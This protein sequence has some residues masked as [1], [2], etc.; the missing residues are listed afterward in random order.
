MPTNIWS[1]E[2]I[3]LKLSLLVHNW[4]NTEEKIKNV[5]INNCDYLVDLNKDV[6][7]DN[8]K[9][10]VLEGKKIIFINSELCHENIRNRVLNEFRIKLYDSKNYKKEC[11]DMM[12]PH[13]RYNRIYDETNGAV[14]DLHT[15]KI[16]HVQLSKDLLIQIKPII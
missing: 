3:D 13:K 8:L 6:D 4:V 15:S 11:F 5:I 10:K 2:S 16:G 7:I 12:I 14:D 1:Q 9:I